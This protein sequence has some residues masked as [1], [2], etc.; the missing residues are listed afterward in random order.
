M[1]RAD[2]QNYQRQKPLFAKQDNR[3]PTAV[4]AAKQEARHL[5][6]TGFLTS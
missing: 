1:G 3:P 2:A 6:V 4:P 5:A